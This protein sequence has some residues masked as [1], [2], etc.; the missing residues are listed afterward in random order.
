V[1]GWF[2]KSKGNT[3]NE[4]NYK[5]YVGKKCVESTDKPANDCYNELGRDAINVKREI[6]GA[7]EL[8]YVKGI[9]NSLQNQMNTQWGNNDKTI[10]PAQIYAD[11]DSD[12]SDCGQIVYVD[13]R[14]PSE[15]DPRVATTDAAV[16]SWYQGLEYY[17]F[18]QGKAVID[19]DMT[20]EIKAER[21]RAADAFTQLVWK[22]STRIGLGIKGKWVI[23]WFCQSKGNDPAD[24]Q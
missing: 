15:Y 19:D 20:P 22:G 4:A 6:H 17:D 16:E 18:A 24:S 23:G 5:K 21:K 10:D 3:G 2:C 13:A 9:A 14:N 11:R 7:N 8:K 1:I 12:Y